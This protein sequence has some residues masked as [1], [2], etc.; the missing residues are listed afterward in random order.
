LIN[1]LKSLGVEL[2][3]LD[4][5]SE[6]SINEFCSLFKEQLDLL[7]NNAG[8]LH[9]ADSSAEIINHFVINALG[10]LLLTKGLDKW[11]QKGKVVFITSSMGSISENESGGLYGYRASKAALNMFVK[12]LSIEASY[13]VVALHPGYIKTD[14]TGNNGDMGPDEAVERMSLV[15]DEFNK[16]STGQF[17]HRDGRVIPW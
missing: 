15:I 17:R 3:Q 11:I 2:L 8:I 10:P 6:S 14:M 1:K 16:T 9:R 4:V 12:T 7:I 13:P 5:S